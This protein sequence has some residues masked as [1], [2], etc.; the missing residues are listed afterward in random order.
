M[1]GI[2]TCRLSCLC[3]SV[4]GWELSVSSDFLA[5]TTLPAEPVDSPLLAAAR[6]GLSDDSGVRGV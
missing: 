3:R 1:E 4:R 5:L 6:N 2:T